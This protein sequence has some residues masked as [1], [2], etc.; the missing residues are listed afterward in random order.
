METKREDGLI[1][2]HA[3]SLISAVEVKLKDGG[4]V[5]LVELRNPW[6]N[7]HEWSG[8]W[9]DAAPEWKKYPE[10]AKELKFQPRADGLFWMS[11][12]SF[13]EIF[14]SVEV[15]RKSMP[16]KRAGFDDPA[17][18]A[19]RHSIKPGDEYA[20]AA[21]K[22]AQ[23]GGGK[24]AGGGGDKEA[25]GP[26]GFRGVERQKPSRPAETKVVLPKPSIAIRRE[27][28]QSPQPSVSYSARRD[29]APG[30]NFNS[31]PLSD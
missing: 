5:R 11:W 8:A 16:T 7:Q 23:G 22:A 1:E 28:R 24:A 19:S 4:A 9:A 17:E 14:T 27:S 25:G 29:S 13:V 31:C 15:C 12:E 3:Y 18:G 20:K 2:G 6:G 21:G 30:R 10:V 26:K